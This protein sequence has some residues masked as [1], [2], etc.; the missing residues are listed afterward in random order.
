M[1]GDTKT[2]STPI[3]VLRTTESLLKAVNRTASAL[4]A[5]WGLVLTAIESAVG[6]AAD[7]MGHGLDPKITITAMRSAL[8]DVNDVRTLIDTMIASKS[9]PPAT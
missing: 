1:P 7:L 3:D 9:R 8:T 2:T 5:P 4:P 6:L